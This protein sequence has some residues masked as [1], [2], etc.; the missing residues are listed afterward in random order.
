MWCVYSCSKYRTAHFHI[1]NCQCYLSAYSFE[2]G[3]CFTEKPVYPENKKKKNVY[4]ARV[5]TGNS[6]N[7]QEFLARGNHEAFDSVFDSAT[8]THIV[9][10]S[11]Q[12]YPEYLITFYW[13]DTTRLASRWCIDIALFIDLRAGCYQNY[14]QMTRRICV[15]STYMHVWAS[16]WYNI[17]GFVNL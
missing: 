14:R 16:L 13:R 1:I 8:K 11:D 4:R 2:D 17:Q 10:S 3:I 5:I 15:K 9:F 7:S 12:T 6:L